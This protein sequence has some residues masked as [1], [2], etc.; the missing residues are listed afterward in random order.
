M[1]DIW[2]VRHAATAWTGIRWCGR[3]DPALTAAGEADAIRLSGDLRTSIGPE[4]GIVSSP[5]RRA[6]ATASAIAAITGREPG[7][8]I[9]VDED[10]LEVDFGRVDGCTFEEIEARFPALSARLAGGETAI[11]WPDGETAAEVR[12]RA[13]R[14]WTRLASIGAASTVVAVTHGGLIATI[15]RE[16]LDGHDR[17]A[18]YPPPATAT[19]LEN[20]DGRWLIHQDPLPSHRTVPRAA[21]PATA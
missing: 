10:L 16:V 21:H 7:T 6:I 2:L 9:A 12:A 19:R 18:D 4:A 8:T 13:T 20:S 11:D 14:A 3:S 5:A 17:P 15:L 1:G